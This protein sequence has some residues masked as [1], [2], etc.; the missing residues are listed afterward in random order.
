MTYTSNLS[1]RK[2]AS[3]SPFLAKPYT[4]VVPARIAEQIAPV[5]R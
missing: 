5:I 1:S 2:K 4:T 3:E